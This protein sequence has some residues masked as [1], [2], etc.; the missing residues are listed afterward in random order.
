S[1]PGDA[2]WAPPPPLRYREAAERDPASLRIAFT[3]RDF[4]GNRARLE[5]RQAGQVAAELCA[6]LGHHVEEAAPAIDGAAYNEAFL[7]LWGMCAGYF[8]KAVARGA[9]E[10]RALPGPVSSWLGEAG[11]ARV[12]TAPNVL[13]FGRRA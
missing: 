9:I 7:V 12:L 2:D 6:E 5:C 13:P 1:R 11:I 10:Q 3:T 4:A 8:V